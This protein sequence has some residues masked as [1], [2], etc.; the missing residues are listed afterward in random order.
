MRGH[1]F[2]ECPRLDAVTRALLNKAYEERMAE[3][4]E[5]YQPRP[6]QTV[7]AVRTS[8]GPPWSSSD[9]TPP[10]GVEAEELVQED[11]SSSENKKR[12]RWSRLPR[13]LLGQQGGTSLPGEPGRT[14][15]SGHRGYPKGNPLRARHVYSFPLLAISY[16]SGYS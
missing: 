3:R 4:P 14:G 10:P 16:S 7:A 2:R 5:E 12:G 1:F 15:L 6:K 13:Q 11:K 8:L 9:D